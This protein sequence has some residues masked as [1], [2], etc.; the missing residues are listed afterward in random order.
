MFFWSPW[1]LV[2]SSFKHRDWVNLS[3]SLSLRN[4]FNKDD[5]LQEYLWKMKAKKEREKADDRNRK[6]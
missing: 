2:G 6:S 4:K 1:L 3:L 5:D